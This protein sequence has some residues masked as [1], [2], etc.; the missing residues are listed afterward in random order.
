MAAI[1][2][3]RFS[4][5]TAARDNS[6]AWSVP[7]STLPVRIDDI[8]IVTPSG[9]VRLGVPFLYTIGDDWTCYPA[10]FQHV[11]PITAENPQGVPRLRDIGGS[12]PDSMST[13]GARSN[14]LYR[15]LR[16]NR[17]LLDRDGVGAYETIAVLRIYHSVLS[18][19]S[20][21]SPL[22]TV[23]QPLTEPM[24]ADPWRLLED[25]AGSVLCGVILRWLC[26][27]D[28]GANLRAGQQYIDMAH[29]ML[30]IGTLAFDYEAADRASLLASVRVWL[31]DI[32]GMHDWLA[33]ALMEQLMRDPAGALRLFTNLRLQLNT[34]ISVKHG[35]RQAGRPVVTPTQRFESRVPWRIKPRTY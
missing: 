4:L 11:F 7:T 22:I 33:S 13:V 9:L 25:G 12:D 15:T 26:P 5:L 17:V 27:Q 21:S 18:Y 23:P 28:P 8:E 1:D 19:V 3:F 20:V 29:R 31:N 14:V 24:Q 10:T 2:A 34:Y 32:P 16:G 35:V 6:S 30:P